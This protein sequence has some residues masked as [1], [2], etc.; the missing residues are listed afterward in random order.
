[1]NKFFSNRNLTLLFALLAALAAA[2]ILWRGAADGGQVAVIEAYG[3]STSYIDLSRVTQPYELNFGGNVILVEP[4]KISMKSADCP[5]KLC[6]RQ[7]KLSGRGVIACLPNR[8]VIQI[9]GGGEVDSVD[10]VVR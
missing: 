4:G 8:V 5:D 9:E 1:M 10:A 3:Y 7:G 2:V 6:V